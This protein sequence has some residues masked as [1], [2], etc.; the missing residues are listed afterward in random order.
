MIAPRKYIYRPLK[1]SAEIRIVLLQPASHIE[2][3]LAIK[4]QHYDFVDRLQC[5]TEEPEEDWTE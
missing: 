3:R 1:Q 2:A 5:E 4:I